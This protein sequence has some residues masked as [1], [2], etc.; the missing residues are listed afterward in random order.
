MY[1]F[2]FV[3][4]LSLPF[5][6]MTSD[7]ATAQSTGQQKPSEK[8][9][10]KTADRWQL[11]GRDGHCSSFK[12]LKQTFPDIP[13]IT[14]PQALQQY[15]KTHEGTPLLYPID[16]PEFPDLKGYSLFDPAHHVSYITLPAAH[17][18]GQFMAKDHDPASR[19]R[20]F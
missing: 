4:A 13:R 20:G 6:V 12:S 5:T 9:T 2:V 10:K 18:K 16:D 19:Q 7:L 3:A 14:T 15:L 17:C 11:L 8:K 1:V